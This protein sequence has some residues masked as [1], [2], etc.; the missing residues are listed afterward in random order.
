MTRPAPARAGTAR[1]GPRGVRTP[2]S[3]RAC[4]TA[5]RGRAGPWSAGRRRWRCEAEPPTPAPARARP[6]TARHVAAAA[7]DDLEV[8]LQFPIGHPVE[9]LPPLPLARGREVVDELVA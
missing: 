8:A 9:P 6:A 2:A 4:G 1:R 5:A 3:S 7:S